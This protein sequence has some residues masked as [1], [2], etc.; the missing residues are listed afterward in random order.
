LCATSS[1]KFI[2]RNKGEREK[3]FGTDPNDPHRRIDLSAEAQLMRYTAGAG[4]EINFNPFNQREKNWPKRLLRGAKSG[5][6]GVKGNAQAAFAIAEGR[7]R[8]ECY[9]PHYAGWHAMWDGAGQSFELGFWRFYGDIVLSGGAGASL[10]V[11][12]ELGVSYAGGKQGLRGIPPQDKGKPGAKVRAGGNG[13]LDVFAGAEAGIDAKGALQWL[14][15]EGEASNGK[16]LKVKDP[17]KVVPEFKDVAVVNPGVSGKAGIGVKGAFKI[18]HDGDRFV[19]H[20][21]LGACLGLGG[22]ASLKFEVG[23]KTIGEFFKCVAYQLKRADFHKMQEAIA[24]D[25]YKTYC[26]IYYLAITEKRQLEEFSH[27]VAKDIADEFDSIQKRIR[28]AIQHG[29][30][31]AQDWLNRIEQSMEGWFIYAPPEIKGML[32][33]HLAD[34]QQSAQ[35]AALRPKAAQLTDRILASAQ[36]LNDRITIAERMTYNLGEKLEASL[37]EAR[38]AALTV[39][40]PY[41][42]CLQRADTQLAKAQPLYGRPFIWNDD[43]AFVVATMGFDHAMF[44]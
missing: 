39:G 36:T 44:A 12:L 23:T 11:E 30:Q 5:E 29:T 3:S 25:A 15:P 40:T 13:E 37:G 1:A 7:V 31:E 4:L 42:N 38:I 20:A 43:A 33:A 24:T 2:E 21:K 28:K 27:K 10:L 34:V 17:L 6:F 8:T 9:W 18:M 41:E 35:M 19:I 16:P 14:N 22:G 32:Q 26:Q